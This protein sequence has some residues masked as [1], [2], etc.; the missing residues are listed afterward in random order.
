MFS[1]LVQ[2]KFQKYNRFSRIDVSKI[3]MEWLNILA[4]CPL[5]LNL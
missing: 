1:H 2:L 4:T 5:M 3:K